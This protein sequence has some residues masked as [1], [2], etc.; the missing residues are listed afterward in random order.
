MSKSFFVIGLLFLISPFVSFGQSY[1]E[2]NTWSNPQW[3]CPGDTIQ[4]TASSQGCDY[5]WESISGNIIDSDS[6]LLITQAGLYIAVSNMPC[7]QAKDTLEIQYYPTPQPNLGNDTTLCINQ[8]DTLSATWPNC[9]YE[10]NTEPRYDSIKILVADPLRVTSR[11][12]YTYSVKVTSLCKSYPVGR[13]TIKVF[14]SF[15]PKSDLPNDTAVCPWEEF[16]IQALDPAEYLVSKYDILWNDGST[17]NEKIV[18]ETNTYSVTITDFCGDIIKDTVA[19][20]VYPKAW[21]ESP[22]PADTTECERIPVTVHAAVDYPYTTYVWLDDTTMKNPVR[23]F[24]TAGEY[25]LQMTDSAGCVHVQKISLTFEDCTP[26]ISVPNAF[27]PNG[28][29]LNDVFKVISA[30]KVYDFEIKIYNRLGGLVKEFKGEVDD[31]QW[32]GRMK[33]GS[34]VS[35]GAYFYVLSYKDVYGKV[36]DQSGSITLLR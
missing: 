16:T 1:K 7:S 30:E 34:E 20:R 3:M 22:M 12:E 18:E 15:P 28:D 19:I 4:A 14:Y 33:G 24:T 23:T 27:S 17:E 11:M 36:Y 10:W 31:F 26:K 35:T 6:V 21:T 2:I 13:D 5:H 25:E 32:D 29:G 8:T 9:I